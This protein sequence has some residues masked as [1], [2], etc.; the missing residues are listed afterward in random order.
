MTRRWSRNSDHSSINMV[1]TDWIYLW[2]FYIIICFWWFW[3][4]IMIW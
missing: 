1:R 4:L 3:I 2:F